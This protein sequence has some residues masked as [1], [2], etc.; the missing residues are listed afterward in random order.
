MS[1]LEEAKS[2]RDAALQ[3][4]RDEL[5]LLKVCEPGSPQWEQQQIAVENTGTAYSSA[6]DEYTKRL[7][8]VDRPKDGAA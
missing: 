8:Q 5:K 6:D 3:A 2:R 1:P 4:W 7:I